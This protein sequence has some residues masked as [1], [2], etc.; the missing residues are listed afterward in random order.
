MRTEEY[1]AEPAV[2]EDVVIPAVE[3]VEAEYD[4]DGNIVVEAVEAQEERTESVLVSEAVM[5][6][7]EVPDYQGID[8]AKLVPLLVATVQE[9]EARIK[10]LENAQ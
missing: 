4:E 5:A 9:L 2:Y 6:E 7:R 1:E 10:T 8:Q 3:A